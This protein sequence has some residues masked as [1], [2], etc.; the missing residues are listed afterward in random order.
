MVG[1]LKMSIG[2]DTLN[3]KIFCNILVIQRVKGKILC[4]VVVVV[5]KDEGSVGSQVKNCRNFSL[6]SRVSEVK[7]ILWSNLPLEREWWAN[8]VVCFA[9][10]KRIWNSLWFYLFNR[11]IGV[12]MLYVPLQLKKIIENF[13]LVQTE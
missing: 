4:F 8:L 13:N 12:R 5:N 7:G 1:W 6:A 11:I 10:R 2:W 9:K 3:V